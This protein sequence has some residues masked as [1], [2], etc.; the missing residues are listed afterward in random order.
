MTSY[1][2]YFSL[3]SLLDLASGGF[4]ENSMNLP[5]LDQ[6]KSSTSVS[7]LVSCQASPPSGE[8][9]QICLSAGLLSP[10]ASSFFASLASSFF[11]GGGGGSTAVDSRS[12]AKA[13]QCPSGDHSA[14]P[15]DFL[16]R[17]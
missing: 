3:R 10:P 16:P 4:A 14:E 2:L 12:V 8:M 7:D 9:I 5:S 17:V 1:S 13:S 15:A 11:W 6:W